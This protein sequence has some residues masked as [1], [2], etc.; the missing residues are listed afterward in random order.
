MDRRGLFI[1]LLMGLI[2][3]WLASF[4]V[5]GGGLVRYIIWGVLGAFIGSFVLPLVGV[6]L[7]LGHPIATQIA[8][9]TVGAILLVLIV[10]LIA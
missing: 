8:V 3:G 2:A 7:N 4:I 9:A 5:G 6:K 1:T 10:R